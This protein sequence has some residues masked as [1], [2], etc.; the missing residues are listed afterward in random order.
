MWEGMNLALDTTK[1][2]KSFPNSVIDTSGETISNPSTI[3]NFFAKY[4]ENIPGKLK[5]KIPK[6]K[7]NYLHYLHKQPR[8]ER[9]L[10]LH[11]AEC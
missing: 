7:K 6:C 8:V 2:K 9:Y 5:N 10:T 4:F 3:A 11:N 1:R